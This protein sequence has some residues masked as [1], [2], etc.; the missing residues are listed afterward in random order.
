MRL[1]ASIQFFGQGRERPEILRRNFYAIFII[2]SF[3]RGQD[4]GGRYRSGE[5]LRSSRRSRGDPCQT[6]TSKQRCHCAVGPIE[7]PIW[8]SG[9]RQGPL[10]SASYS[11][12]GTD[13]G[14]PGF[15]PESDPVSSRSIGSRATKKGKSR[16]HRQ[17][18]RAGRRDVQG[19]VLQGFYFH[20]GTLS[21]L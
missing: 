10:L 21:Q 16:I 4:S 19:S 5:I 3:H 17:T 12:S 14:D 20:S 13:Q 11:N 1:P 9:V 2:E 18:D 7:M 8:L 15:L 6:D